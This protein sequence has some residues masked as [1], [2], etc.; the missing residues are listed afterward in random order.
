[1]GLVASTFVEVFIFIFLNTFIAA[2]EKKVFFPEAIMI[3]YHIFYINSLSNSMFRA[4][5]YLIC[6]CCTRDLRQVEEKYEPKSNDNSIEEIPPIEAAPLE[7]KTR[8]D[9][10]GVTDNVE[11]R[12]C[13]SSE[14]NIFFIEDINDDISLQTHRKCRQISSDSA[15][16]KVDDDEETEAET[17]GCSSS[18]SSYYQHYFIHIVKTRRVIK[19]K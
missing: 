5:R 7:W 16:I 9:E 15:D 19:K 3:T 4:K 1:M 2:F 13:D 14:E 18:S 11:T 17:T 8:S 12:R 10:Y 6:C